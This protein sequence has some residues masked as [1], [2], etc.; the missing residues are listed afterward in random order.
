M[1]V[2]IQEKKRLFEFL[3]KIKESYELIAP[4]KKDLV[5]FEKV[6]DAKD[7]HLENNSYFPVK[8]YFF[9][10]EEIL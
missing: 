1:Q 8:G 5:R 7:I 3:S 4:V 10:N 2:F 9:K 6:N